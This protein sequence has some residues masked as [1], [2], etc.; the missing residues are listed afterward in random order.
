MNVLKHRLLEV[1]WDIGEEVLNGLVE[2]MPQRMRALLKAK[3]G[4]L[5]ID[6]SRSIVSVI[7]RISHENKSS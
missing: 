6:A 5:S 7:K 3:A 1:W 2:S 4:T